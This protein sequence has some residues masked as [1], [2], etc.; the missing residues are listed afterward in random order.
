MWCKNA[1]CITKGCQWRWFYVRLNLK[2]HVQGQIDTVTDRTLILNKIIFENVR[3]D[4]CL[5]DYAQVPM[6]TARP[7]TWRRHSSSQLKRGTWPVWRRCWATVPTPTSTATR[8]SG[9]YPSTPPQSS[10]VSGQAK[11]LCYHWALHLAYLFSSTQDLV[12][13]VNEMPICGHLTTKIQIS[14]L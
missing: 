4:I 11:G 13:W 7:L 3:Y 5:C 2:L 14:P 1:S 8:T 6:W 12:V 9:S 10:H